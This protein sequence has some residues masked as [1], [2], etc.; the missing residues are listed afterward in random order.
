MKR[1]ETK[2]RKWKNKEAKEEVGNAWG[3]SL[4]R[5][6]AVGGA[7]GVKNEKSCR[8]GAKQGREERRRLSKGGVEEAEKE[9]TGGNKE[10]THAEK[11]LYLA[12]QYILVYH[13]P[14]IATVNGITNGTYIYANTYVHTSISPWRFISLSPHKSARGGAG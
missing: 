5:R 4:I 13:Q 6:K 12:R 8:K 10:D 11:T 9:S 3:T 1:N 14:D 7:H 2:L